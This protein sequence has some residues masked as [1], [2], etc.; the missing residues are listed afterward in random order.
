MEAFFREAGEPA[1]ERVLPE[2]RPLDMERIGAAA[3][4]TGAVQIL[5]PP[6]FGNTG[7]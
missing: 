5:M 2:P 3:E 7:G 1:A 6:P 4:R